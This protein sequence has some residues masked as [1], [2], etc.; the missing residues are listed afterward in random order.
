[1]DT[2]DF[3]PKSPGAVKPREPECFA[4]ALVIG[5]FWRKPLQGGHGGAM[6]FEWAIRRSFAAGGRWREE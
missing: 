2:C 5:R 1:M 6:G 3:Y 4:P